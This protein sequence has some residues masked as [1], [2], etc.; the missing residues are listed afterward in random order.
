MDAPGAKTTGVE[1]LVRG[2]ACSGAGSVMGSEVTAGLGR[3]P[4]A[5]AL[6]WPWPS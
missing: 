3:C 4:A 6:V 5:R 2:T 1:W